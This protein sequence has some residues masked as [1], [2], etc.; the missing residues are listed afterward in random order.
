[1]RDEHYLL[2]TIRYSH[3]TPP[4]G[5]SNTGY[6]PLGSNPRGTQLIN[7]MWSRGCTVPQCSRGPRD[8]PEGSGIGG[9]AGSRRGPGDGLGSDV[10][11]AA[12]KPTSPG[13][14]A[15]DRSLV[16]P[17]RSAPRSSPT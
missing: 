14:A 15:P 10:D 8:G 3:Y 12:S 9:V 7:H 1:H 6:E 11:G 2:H 5:C 4:H 17:E 16:A 13:S